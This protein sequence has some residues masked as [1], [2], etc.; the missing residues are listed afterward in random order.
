MKRSFYAFFLVALGFTFSTNAA[1]EVKINHDGTN[2]LVIESDGTVKAEGTATTWADLNVYPDVKSSSGGTNPTWEVFLNSVRLWKFQNSAEVFFTVQLPHS[3][4]EGTTIY[5]HV[6]WAASVAAASN[7]QVTW[8][9]EYTWSNHKESFVG[10]ATATGNTCVDYSTLS[11]SANQHLI[12][13][14]TSISGS[15]KGIS[16]VLVCRLYRNAT[17]TYSTTGNVF[18]IGVDF[19]YEMDTQGSRSDFLK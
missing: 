3:Y 7:K 11:Y 18:L 16:S 5:P 2:G 9:L 12:T 1:N 14:L 10:T 13:P 6:H 4:K 8:N 19:H 17:D 15:S